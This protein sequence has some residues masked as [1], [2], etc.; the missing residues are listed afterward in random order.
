MSILHGRT[1]KGR[2][3]VEAAQGDGADDPP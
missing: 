3:S 1:P 2:K